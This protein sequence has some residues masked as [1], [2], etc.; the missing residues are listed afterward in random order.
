MNVPQNWSYVGSKWSW[1]I[2]GLTL[3][4][5]LVFPF[6]YVRIHSEEEKREKELEREKERKRA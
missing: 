2:M 1:W 3:L 4:P 6:V 5:E